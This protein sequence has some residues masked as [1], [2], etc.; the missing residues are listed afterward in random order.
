MSGSRAMRYSTLAPGS[1]VMAAGE[2]TAP[3]PI[4]LSQLDSHSKE[5]ACTPSACATRYLRVLAG[6]E[7]G[8]PYSHT[9]G[10]GIKFGT[11]NAYI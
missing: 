6:S 8:M 11:F 7:I 10:K 2:K 1:Q 4:A 9:I 5:M 3:V